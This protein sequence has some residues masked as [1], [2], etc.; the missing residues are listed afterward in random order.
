MLPQGILI[1]LVP[2]TNWSHHICRTAGVF[3]LPRSRSRGAF[4]LSCHLDRQVDVT[5]SS[6][7]TQVH[8]E[9][10]QTFEDAAPICR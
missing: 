6:N 9:L 1:A 10:T 7:C 3:T 4:C 8:F 5:K 2:L